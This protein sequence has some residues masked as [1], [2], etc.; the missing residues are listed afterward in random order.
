MAGDK[1]DAYRRFVRGTN[2]TTAMM[3]WI[4]I[5]TGEQRVFGLAASLAWRL[6]LKTSTVKL[7]GGLQGIV[8]LAEFGRKWQKFLRHA[9]DARPAL[10]SDPETCRARNQP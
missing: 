7:G 3:I 9:G 2:A 4:C 6:D 8:F 5:F 1:A 10:A